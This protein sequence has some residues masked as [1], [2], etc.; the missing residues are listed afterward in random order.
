MKKILLFLMFALFCVPWAANAQDTLTVHDENTTTNSYVPVWGLWADNSLQC[1][2][3]YPASEL[4]EMAGGVISALKF[5]TNSTSTNIGNASASSNWDGTFT[6]FMKEVEATTLSDFTGTTGATTVLEAQIGVVNGE[7]TIEFTN[8]Y[9]Y[10]GGNL[11]VG[12]YYATGG[13]YCSVTWVGNSV[14]GASIYGRSGQSYSATQGNFIPKTTFIYTPGEAACAKPESIQVPEV[15]AY[16]ANVAWEGGSGTYQLQ[17]K[18]PTDEDWEDVMFG[19]YTSYSFEELTPATTYEVRVRSLCGEDPETGEP[20]VSF[21]KSTS[22]TTPC[23]IITSYP[24]TTNFDDVAGST[25]GTTNNLPMC[26]NYIN[27]RII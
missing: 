24:W 26:W 19:S 4:E 23:A 7:M 20:L 25:S 17:L 22:F 13:H 12:I 21:W 18:A 9:T 6:I 8:P 27:S 5:Y 10:G 3:V 2:I 1:E 15:T 16:S 11:L 14:T